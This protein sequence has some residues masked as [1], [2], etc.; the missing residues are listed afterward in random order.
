MKTSE[1][2][3]E[4]KTDL[5]VPPVTTTTVDTP[6]ED[7][8]TYDDLGYEVVAAAPVIPEVVV[9]PVV[10]V[11]PPV[12]EVKDETKVEKTAT[13]YGAEE[14]EEVVPPVEEKPKTPEQ[15]TEEE[16]IKT[17]ITETIKDLGV[18]WDKE[19][20]TKFA[21]DNK[22]SKDQLAAYVKMAKDDDTASATAE[23]ARV[24]AQRKEWNKSL[25]DDPEFGGEHFDKNVDRVE[26]LLE[27]NLPNTKKALTDKKG[28]LPPYLMRDL[29]SLAKVL[30]PTT[31]LVKGGAPAP[32]VET[33]GYLDELY[34]M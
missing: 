23:K 22:L 12:T 17:E 6:S 11:I 33:Q 18:G 25:K 16:K 13:G 15:L 24:T 2:T 3:T 19:K 21:I 20:I 30:N 14:P 7:G 5:T 29:L 27:K 8:K 34:P 26:K 10:E 4:S 28:M 1:N 32:K 9:P 31:P